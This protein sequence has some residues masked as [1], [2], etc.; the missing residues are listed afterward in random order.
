MCQDFPPAEDKNNNVVIR[1]TWAVEDATFPTLE[2]IYAEGT[3]GK[4]AFNPIVKL[5]STLEN[6][7][8]KI[9][10]RLRGSDCPLDAFAT[11][12]TM[13]PIWAEK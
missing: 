12:R 6:S 11:A 4:T 1:F 5:S 10:F 3:N 8:K 9:R 13:R 2:N 7:P